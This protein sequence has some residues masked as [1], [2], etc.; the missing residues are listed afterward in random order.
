MKAS[1]IQIHWHIEAASIYSAHFEPCKKGRLATAGGDGNVRIWRVERSQVVSQ[2]SNESGNMTH[3]SYSP[4]LIYLSTLSKH[5][6]AVNVVRF[7]P[8]GGLLA[9]AGDDG[10][11]LIWVLSDGIHPSLSLGNEKESDDKET[12][13]IFRFCRSSGAEIYDLAWSPDAAYLLTGSMDHV[14]R[15]YN[16]N[17][18]QCIQQLSEHTHYI[19]GVAWDPLN[20]YIATTGSDRTVQIYRIDTKPKFSVTLH[21]SLSRME[22]STAVGMYHN[23]TLLSFFRR[24]NF[25][26]D[27][28]L[29]LVP[30]GQYRYLN[31]SEETLNTVYIYTRAGLNRSPVA[32][33]PGH[34]RPAIIVSCSPKYYTLRNIEKKD[35]VTKTLP[36]VNTASQNDCVSDSVPDSIL[37]T[38]TDTS[39]SVFDS[40]PISFSLDYRMVYA[41][42]T[43]DTIVLY[44]TQHVN[45]IGMLSNFH[46]ATLT[47]LAW[48]FDGN[49]LLITS[50]DGYCSI[51]LFDE[52]ELGEEYISPFS[53][54]CSEHPTLLNDPLKVSID[55]PNSMTNIPFQPVVN[56]QSN[57]KDDVS[58]H[59]L[60]NP[61]STTT[62][63][64]E[65]KKR[66]APTLVQFFD[67]K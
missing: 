49:A 55:K 44:D 9:S 27:G 38:F 14:A 59:N 15:I 31:E 10:N 32:H 53:S 19:Q 30:A 7:S 23:E 8:R 28:N 4:R 12:W 57:D 25:T 11:V 20:T 66:I 18:G 34:K 2:L 16:V 3:T 22:Y 64:K 48:S 36:I 65:K 47:D 37:D 54:S 58:S 1:V 24:L 67:N 45:P 42:A 46:Y 63:V 35:E 39:K 61:L 40:A 5:T 52:N 50:T 21:A 41:V 51:A 33:L 60:E 56:L 43:Q 17:E 26:P 6:Q 29:L 13:K 62:I